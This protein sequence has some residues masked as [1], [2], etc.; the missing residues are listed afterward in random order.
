VATKTHNKTIHPKKNKAI[1]EKIK[2]KILL[3]VI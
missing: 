2:S 3:E 1:I